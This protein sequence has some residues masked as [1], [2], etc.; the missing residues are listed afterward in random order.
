MEKRYTPT[1][2]W[3][4]LN[5]ERSEG[6][7]GITDFAQQEVTDVVFVE[8]PKVGK[9]VP[10]GGEAAIIESVKAAFSIYAPMGGVIIS[11]NQALDGNPGLLN[12]DP[13]G[14]GWI[15]RLKVTHPEEFSDLMDEKA[16]QSYLSEGGGQPAHG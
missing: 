11:V 12:Q 7:V 16:Y 14:Q 6:T 2:E 15:F 1:H 13:T 4:E 10:R 5:Q 3:V 8:L 9:S